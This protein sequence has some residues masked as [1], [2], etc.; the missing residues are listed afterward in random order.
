MLLGIGPAM[1][2]QTLLAALGDVARPAGV[3]RLWRDGGLPIAALIPGL[4]ADAY[5]MVTVIGGTSLR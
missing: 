4:L 2:D 3:C 1:V 5:G